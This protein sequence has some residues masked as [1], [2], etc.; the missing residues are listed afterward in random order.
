[1]ENNTKFLGFS[2]NV[3]NSQAVRKKY[4]YISENKLK[5]FH[6]SSEIAQQVLEMQY[7]LK[8]EVEIFVFSDLSKL[9]KS[10]E[11]QI[12][13]MDIYWNDVY[14]II[15][16]WRLFK[17][18]MESC[19]ELNLSHDRFDFRKAKKCVLGRWRVEL[20]TNVAN[21]IFYWYNDDVPYATNVVRWNGKTRMF[22]INHTHSNNLVL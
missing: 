2:E 11:K 3:S 21:K 4:A 6:I 8:H 5:A 1:M 9:E 13:Y 16:W 7:V 20:M 19:R 15:D 12:K 22:S 17:G 14:Y 18:F 10:W